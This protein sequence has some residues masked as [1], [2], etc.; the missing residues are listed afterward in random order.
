MQLHTLVFPMMSNGGSLIA[1]DDGVVRGI[2]ANM[3]RDLQSNLC[4]VCSI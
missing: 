3:R 2:G 1:R 4:V